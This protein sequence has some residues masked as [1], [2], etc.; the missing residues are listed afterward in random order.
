MSENKKIKSPDHLVDIFS[1]DTNLN[2]ESDKQN[3]IL[4]NYDTLL[5]AGSSVRGFVIL[6]G[7]QYFYENY[8]TK[9]L[10]KFIGTS[11]GSIIC[12]LLCIGY[13]P[14]EILVYL[15]VNGYIFE[16]IQNSFNLVEMFN[17]NGVTSF[18]LIQD[19][20][21]KMTI[22]KIGRLITLRELYDDFKKTLTVS[23]YNETEGRTE[24]ISYKNKP[25]MPCLVA[26]RMSSNLP[27]VFEQF[28]YENSVYIDGG[29]GDNFPIQLAE[30]EGKRIMA[31]INLPDKLIKENE[32]ILERIMRRSGIAYNELINYKIAL[33]NSDKSKIITFN[34]D[35]VKTI[36]FNV[37]SEKRLNMFSYGYQHAKSLLT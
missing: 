30:N 34:Y 28:I 3:T 29:L 27:E 37:D 23:T 11:S 13:K 10:N 18:R 33:S 32:N 8:I 2:H 5:L 17:G 22:S 25:N 7:L 36:Q 24:Y 26:L 19:F 14:L 9:D 35:E 31:M 4:E 1:N 6:G 21:E 16:K 20:L 12:Y 15:S